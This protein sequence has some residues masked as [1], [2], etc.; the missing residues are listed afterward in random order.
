[1]L[2][3]PTPVSRLTEIRTTGRG[4]DRAM[5]ILQYGLAILALAGALLLGSFR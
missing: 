5:D 3:L 2:H 1:M 4:A